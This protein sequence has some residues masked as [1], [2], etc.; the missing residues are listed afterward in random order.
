MRKKTRGIIIPPETRSWVKRL[1]QEQK[2]NLLDAIYAYNID[3]EILEMDTSV[4]IVFDMMRDFFDINIENYDKISEQN[5]EKM[6]KRWE[7]IQQNTTDTV[8]TTV[9]N[10]IQQ[11]TTA[12]NKDKINKIKE[13]KENINKENKTETDIPIGIWSQ[14]I[15]ID[16]KPI[17]NIDNRNNET[18]RIIDIVKEQV[19]QEWLIYDNN[20]EER[21][22]ATI[23][24]KRQS[25]WWEFIK[26]SSK[27]Y[28]EKVIKSI[29]SYSNQ[30]EYSA[31]I[32][33]VKDFHEKWKKVAND[34]KQKIIKEE[35]TNFIPKF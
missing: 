16:K 6:R 25:D 19:Q 4:W 31:K 28:E 34:M 10:G 5:A 21:H 26:D 33:S 13:N 9:Y 3:W 15:V 12:T 14:A 18:Q 20:K 8:D 24:W 22:R 32:R 30:N 35:K 11:N 7:C 29:V 17:D 27:E 23:I 2:W 1:T